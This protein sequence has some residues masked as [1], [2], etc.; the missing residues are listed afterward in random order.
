MVMKMKWDVIK[1]KMEEYEGVQVRL[2]Q[3]SSEIQ[4]AIDDYKVS[5]EVQVLERAS[6]M[7]FNVPGFEYYQSSY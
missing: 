3:L 7:G 4:K 1:Q 6:S 2:Q 5:E